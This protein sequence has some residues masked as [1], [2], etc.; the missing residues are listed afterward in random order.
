MYTI[1]ATPNNKARTYTIRQYDKAI[2]I[3]KFRTFKMNKQDFKSNQ[4][5]T[6]N[7][8]R[9]YLKSDEYYKIR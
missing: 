2:L 8:W 1:T 4:Y 6:L 7:D 3:S 9:N 5:N